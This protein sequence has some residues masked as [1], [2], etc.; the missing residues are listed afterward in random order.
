MT[1]IPTAVRALLAL[2]IALAA[3]GLG[4]CGP[5]LYQIHVNGYTDPAAPG[6]I[7]PGG[8]FFVI[9]NREAKNPLLEK[10]IKEKIVRLLEQRGYR[11]APYEQAQYYLFFTYGLGP[12]RSA[13]VVM[14]EYGWGFGTGYGWP[15]AYLLVAPFFSYSGGES[16]YDRW[17]LLNVVDGQHYRERK[18]FRTL[19]VGEARSTGSSADLR[20]AVNYLL[21]ADF[22]ELGSNTG[23]A[24]TVEINE[25]AP[26][27]QGLTR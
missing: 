27:T 9:E 2:L 1:R 17:L 24:V 25:Q 23:R 22:K 11:M 16:L 13:S 4:G 7:L 21:L 26:Q 14:P 10:E 19:W 18:E 3:S 20:V 12:E 5:T 15:G 6:A 8:S